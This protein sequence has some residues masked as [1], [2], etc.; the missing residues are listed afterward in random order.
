MH[1][2]DRFFHKHLVAVNQECPNFNEYGD[3]SPCSNKAVKIRSNPFTM[4]TSASTEKSP[5]LHRWRS[6]DNHLTLWKPNGALSLLQTYSSECRDSRSSRKKKVNNPEI[7]NLLEHYAAYSG[8]TLPSFWNFLDF[9]NLD[10]TE[11]LP[12]N[13]GKEITTIRCVVS[14]QSADL[15]CIAMEAWNQVRYMNL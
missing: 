5:T 8:N 4:T 14:Q 10:G 1:C 13:V 7:Y 11:R 6:Y 9:L 3:S 15:I 2:N 12:R